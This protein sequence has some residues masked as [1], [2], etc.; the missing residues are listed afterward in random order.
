M[1]TPETFSFQ[2]EVEE[3][4][5]L[6]IH[7]LYSHKEI[8]LRELLSNASDALDKLR[9]EALTRPELVPPDTRLSIRIDVDREQRRLSVSDDGIGSASTRASWSRA[10]SWSRPRAR[11]RAAARAGARAARASSRSRISRARGAAR[12]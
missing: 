6:M 1:T 10:R 7:S 5:G 3:L 12:R 9:I 11:A 4:L 8:F 2:A